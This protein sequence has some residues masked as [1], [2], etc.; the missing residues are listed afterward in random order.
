MDQINTLN[1]YNGICQL[2]LNRKKQKRKAKF[3]ETQLNVEGEGMIMVLKAESRLFDYS[4]NKSTL[5]SFLLSVVFL[6]II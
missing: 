5:V 1:L 4:L 3:P 6:T 2:C